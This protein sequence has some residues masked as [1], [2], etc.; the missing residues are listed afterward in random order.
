MTDTSPQMV[1]EAREAPER[2]ATLLAADGELYARLGERLRARPSTFAVTI[3]RGSSDH[4]ASYAAYLLQ[5]Y[6]GCITASLPPS[7]WT[8]AR[9]DL[10]LDGALA[11]AVS[12][13]GQ[14]PD[15]I[16]TLSM[17]RSRGALTVAVVNDPASPLA[18]IAEL[19]FCCHAGP[20]KAVAAT[21]SVIATLAVLVRLVVAWSGNSELAAAFQRLPEAVA[22]AQKLLWSA[23]LIRHLLEAEACFLISRGPGLAIAQE[24]AL[25]LQEL[26]GLPAMGFSSAEFQHGPK[27][28]LGPAHP[29]LLLPAEG[30]MGEEAEALLDHVLIADTEN[31]LTRPEPLHP[32]LDPILMLAAFH[33]AAA[34]LARARGCDPDR[35]QGL[36]KVT[37]TR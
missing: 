14:G 30:W 19:S 7:L 32:D 29:A 23:A 28:M 13:S 1:Q 5:R 18:E 37:R 34:D 9:A 16:E 4:A 2:L 12:Q 24:M 10:R 25:K 35:P 20:E 6:C 3:A 8:R 22:K 27:A 17:A 31:G 33:A 15:V 11:I 26:A 21:K 36:S